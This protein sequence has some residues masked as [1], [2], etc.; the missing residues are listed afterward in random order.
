MSV[1]S[2]AKGVENSAYDD[3]IF[4]NLDVIPDGGSLHNSVGTNVN[5][6]SDL[7]GI[8][9]KVATV[10]LVRWSR[11]IKDESVYSVSGKK[12]EC[13]LKTQPSPTRQ[14]LP[15][16][17]TTAWPGPVRLRSPRMMAPLDIIVFPPKIMF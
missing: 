3:T 4:P 16:E 10:R 13:D 11:N 6:I 15:N 14:Y 5:M 2:K 1:S 9:I 17:M 12:V 7:H 8:I